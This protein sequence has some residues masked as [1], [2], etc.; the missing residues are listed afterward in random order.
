MYSALP[1]HVR[2]SEYVWSLSSLDEFTDFL[3]Y[4]KS[5]KFQDTPNYDHLKKMMNVLY[6]KTIKRE[7]HV[8]EWVTQPLRRF[9]GTAV[10]LEIT[11][12]TVSLSDAAPMTFRH[13]D[14]SKLRWIVLLTFLQLGEVNHWWRKMIWMSSQAITALGLNL[15]MSI[16]NSYIIR[17]IPDKKA[18]SSQKVR[19]SQGVVPQS[20]WL[21]TRNNL[22][23][24]LTESGSNMCLLFFWCLHLLIALNMSGCNCFYAR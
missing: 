3:T 14:S 10:S 18:M 22:G 16:G 8:C 24:N 7:E 11:S 17:C 4:V 20:N 19:K 15:R 1:C 23:R 9:P 13:A 5:I 6:N 21:Q 2:Y 12:P